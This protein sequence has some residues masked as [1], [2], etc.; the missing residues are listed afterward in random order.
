M[1]PSPTSG[2]L[3]VDPHELSRACADLERLA[4]SLEEAVGRLAPEAAVDAPGRDEVSVTTAA[5][6]TAVAGRFAE[7]ATSGIR[8]LRNIAAM[9]RSHAGGLADADDQAA[10]GLRT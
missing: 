7:D 1:T 8:Q 3:D 9:L 4:L 10:S 2:N 6:A 5:S